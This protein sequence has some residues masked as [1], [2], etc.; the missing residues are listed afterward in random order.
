MATAAV[1]VTVMVAATVA[2]LFAQ[3]AQLVPVL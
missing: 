3:H 2:I 1:M